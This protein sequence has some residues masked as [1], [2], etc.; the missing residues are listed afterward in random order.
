MNEWMPEEIIDPGS[1]IAS[2]ESDF[3]VVLSFRNKH[4][5]SSFFALTLNKVGRI[6]LVEGVALHFDFLRKPSLCSP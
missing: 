1:K 4:R 5:I 2:T 6:V 3:S